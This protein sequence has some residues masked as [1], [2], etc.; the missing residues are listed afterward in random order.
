MKQT[1]SKYFAAVLFIILISCSDSYIKH[2]SGLMYKIIKTEPDTEKLMLGDIIIVNM[3]YEKSDGKIL[4]NTAEEQRAYIVKIEEPSHKG[5]S[6]E[7]ALL[8]LS[9]G[10]SAVF[11]VNAENYFLYTEKYESLPAYLKHDDELIFKLKVLKKYDDNDYQ[12]MFIDKYHLNEDIELELLENY[13]KITN[14][15]VLPT[16]SGIYYIAKTKGNG[17]IPQ[18]NDKLKVNYSLTLIDGSLIE[19]TLGKTPMEFVLGDTRLIKGFNE[20]ISY[21]TEGEK[22]TVIIPS[23]MAYGTAGTSK[24]LPYTTLIFDIELLQVN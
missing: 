16:S 3:T 10:D 23:K 11:K 15:T 17:K 19:T 21:M 18:E 14:T 24:I 2:E 1:I 20:A 9:V 8:L 13:L 22:A 4:Y 5:G 7:D 6:F 12:R